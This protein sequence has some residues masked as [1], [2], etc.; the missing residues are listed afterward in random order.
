MSTINRMLTLALKEA[1]QIVRDRATLGMVLG[2]PLL[3]FILFGFAVELTPHTLSVT[4]VASQGE[5]AARIE[6]WLKSGSFGERVSSAPSLQYA[7]DRLRRGETLVVVDASQRPALLYVDATDPVL[8]LYA[9]AAIDRVVRSLAAP[10][11]E[12]DESARAVR[13]VELYNPGAQTQPYLVSG[14]VGLILTMTLVM[15][16]ALTLARERERG[17]LE[18]LLTLRVR[19]LELCIGKLTPY[20][21]LGLLQGALILALARLAFEIPLRGSLALIAAAASV[22][23]AANLA[24]G[25]LFSSLARVQMQAMQMTFFFFLPSSLLSG[26]M[27]PFSAMPAWARALGGALPLTHFLRII[28]GVTLRNV[29]AGYVIGELVPIAAFALVAGFAALLSCRRAL[30]AGPA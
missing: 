5:R 10:A 19:P 11:D 26:F 7:Q 20:L 3:Q 18:S 14:L 6:R 28:R 30:R 29:D 15:M 2:V 21:L 16:S 9:K 25:F 1:L 17:S 13:V 12:E 8:Y 23:A 24:L 22:F 27:F 4:V